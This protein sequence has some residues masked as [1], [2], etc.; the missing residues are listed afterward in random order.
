L[1]TVSGVKH[2]FLLIDK[3]AGPTSHDIVAQVRRILHEKKV[4]HL[5]TLD[6]AAS[7][8]MVLAVGAKA[9]KVVEFFN[10][11]SKEYI[12]DIEL[13]SVSSTY[14]RDGVIEELTPKPGWKQPDEEQVIQLLRQQFTGK[15]DQVPPAHSAVH[16]DGNR[17]YVLAR[18]G[19][20]VTIPSR[21]VDITACD[22]L[23]YSYPKIVLRVGCSS[24]TYIRSIA[25]DLG[26]HLRCGA[27]LSGL[28]RTKV[29][30]WSVDFAVSP[31][32]VGW[33]FIVPLKEVLTEFDGIELTDAEAEDVRHGRNI[34][35]EVKPDTIAWHN[36]LPFAVLIPA[37]DGTQ[38]AHARKVF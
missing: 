26:Q 22:L 24:G 18:L 17:A 15:I 28:R 10:S 30:E 36:D 34:K 7:G 35:R 11:L 21:T 4:G 16:V 1:G 31:E 37:K 32:S 5:G 25:H 38:K 9:L 2:G 27:Y 13:G 20:D 6:P 8:L 19:K 14:D 29:G 3:P 23:S 33:S 12:A